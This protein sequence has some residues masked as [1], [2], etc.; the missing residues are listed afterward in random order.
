[1]ASLP[2]IVFVGGASLAG[3]SCL[4]EAAAHRLGIS[5]IS[6]AD[7]SIAIQAVT[8]EESHPAL[9]EFD[10]RFRD[11]YQGS[12]TRSNETA[13]TLQTAGRPETMSPY[14]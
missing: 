1:M 14:S 2:R 13:I 3:K 8:T 11:Y 5:H 10:P 4:A 7:L 9:H 12:S 6:T